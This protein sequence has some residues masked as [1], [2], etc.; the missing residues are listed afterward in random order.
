MT[1][2]AFLFA[3]QGSQTVG[4]AHDLYEYS[5]IVRE[6]F[7]QASQILGYDIR[8]LIDNQEDKLHQTRYTQPAILTTS[9]AI[10]RLLVEKGIQPDMVA[11][12]SLGEYSALVAS[13][14]LAFE[15]GIALIAKRGEYMETAAPAGTGKMVA[16]LNTDVNLIEEVCSSVTSGIVS[17]ANYNTPAQIVIGGEVAAVDEAVELLKEAG[18][19]RMIPLNVSGPFHTALLRPASEQLAQALEQVEFADFQV[20]LVGNTEAK[21]MKKE[22]IKSLLTRQVM[23][24]VRFYESIATMQEA[25]VTNFIEIGPGKVL[26]GFVKKIDKTAHVVAIEDI[27]GLQIVLNKS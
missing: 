23:E 16:V 5:P 9:L 8:D 6:T 21:V 22:D 24:P 10:Y 15:D 25:G 1:K 2:T 27:E 17:P 26:S 18:V 11:G 4:M 12:L 14:A 19:K 3:G 13:G 20:E 7:D